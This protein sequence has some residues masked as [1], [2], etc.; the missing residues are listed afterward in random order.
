MGDN[1]P[2]SPGRVKQEFKM[3]MPLPLMHT[4]SGNALYDGPS[5]PISNGFT[6]PYAT[7]QG[8][9]SKNKLPPGAVDLPKVF[10]NAMRLAPTTPSKSGRQQLSPHSPNKG[11]RQGME[12]N[13]DE[14][15]LSQDYLQAPV[16]ALR[17]S[18][19]ENTSPGGRT[20]KE[21]NNTTSQA[22][23]SRQEPYQS[24]EASETSTRGRYSPTH[25]LTAEEIEKLQLPKVKRLANLTQICKFPHCLDM[26][27]EK[28]C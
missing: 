23:V 12:D 26:S 10:E 9:P 20:G 1:H 7:P 14:N 25:G 16:S 15:N 11:S 19:K 4:R 13:I 22:A 18:N 8:S 2:L 27:K 17:K 24:R 6:T 5:T 28:I 21:F 3:P